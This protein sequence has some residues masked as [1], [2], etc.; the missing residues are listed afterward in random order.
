MGSQN[1]LFR[2]C[3]DQSNTPPLHFAPEAHTHA[4]VALAWSKEPTE[5]DII[6]SWPGSNQITS[7]KVPTEF[8]YDFRGAQEEPS[9]NADR[10][11][12]SVIDRLNDHYQTQKPLKDLR[13]GFQIKGNASRVRC[14]KLFLDRNQS[15]PGFVSSDQ[16]VEDLKKHGRN[17]VDAAADYLAKVNQHSIKTLQ[18]RYGQAFIGSTRIDYILTVPAMWSERAKNATIVAARR[19]GMLQNVRLISEPE[20]AAVYTLKQ[21]KSNGLEIGSNIIVCDAGGG[22]VDL[23]SY[24]LKNTDPIHVEE[25][26]AGT[27]GLCGAVFLN[28][29]FKDH[30]EQRM[31]PES[32]QYLLRVKPL[33]WHE[34]W[35][36]FEEY[37]KRYFSEDDEDL[38]EFNVPFPGCDDNED[39]GIVDGFM[40]LTLGQVREIFEPV[41]KAVLGLVNEQVTRV[42][43]R[44]ELV[45]SIILV[46]GFGQSTYLYE[47]MQKHFKT[48]HPPAYSQSS[49]NGHVMQS[50]DKSISILRPRY[51][52]TAVAR[53][54]AMRALEGPIVRERRARFHYGTTCRPIF[55]PRKHPSSSRHWDKLDRCCRANKAM[56]WYIEKDSL[57][58]E[59]RATCF[60]FKNAFH[61][62][63]SIQRLPLWKTAEA[64]API[65][66]HSSMSKVCTV[67][68]DLAGVP[69]RLMTAR[70]DEDG[71][72]WR[73]VN[74]VVEL[75]VDSASFQW[76]MKIDGSVYGS[77]TANFDD[78]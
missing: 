13:W 57:M 44:D 3:E 18:Q 45:S 55:D 38:E 61:G 73:V 58:S 47:R 68:C 63:A 25:S 60:H 77:V 66:H 16:T 21:V 27:G 71:R 14:I 36:H 65:M 22:T 11:I 29:R 10:T 24:R 75:R 53:G 48:N 69:S 6:K 5:I 20:A 7:D 43:Q 9:E 31:G 46:G 62:T 56:K 4:S 52:W 19:A 15:L 32:F 78:E 33:A 59:D 64:S 40:Q 54:A 35:R 50:A 12:S 70:R 42:H 76:Q 74:F 28:Y 8:T 17:I 39:A 72:E 26:Q 67:E 1:K 37:V 30:V 51:A 23:I 41:V 49:A 2:V 34:A